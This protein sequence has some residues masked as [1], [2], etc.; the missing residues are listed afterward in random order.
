MKKRENPTKH[1]DILRQKSSSAAD[2]DWKPTTGPAFRKRDE[3]GS[4]E[5]KSHGLEILRGKQ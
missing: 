1:I 5:L 4:F 2:Y 3:D